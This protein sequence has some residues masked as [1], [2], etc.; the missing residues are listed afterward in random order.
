MNL[1]LIKDLETARKAARAGAE[2]IRDQFGRAHNVQ[3]KS[4]SMTLVTDTDKAAETA[5]I[6][7]LRN[8]SQ[9][10]VLSEESGCSGKES[11]PIWIVDPLDG[12]SN[13]VRS[14][15]LFAVS[16]ALVIQKN[17]LLGV[18]FDPV[19][20]NEYYAVSER[21]ACFNN[22][23]VAL[24]T[25]LSKIPS[26]IL[27]HGAHPS[28]KIKYSD[29]TKLLA[30]DFNLRKLG[31]TALELCFVAT[32]AFD[33][34]ICAGDEIWDYTAGALIAAEAGNIFSDWNGNEW[35]GINNSIIVCKPHLRK[36][37]LK[38]LQ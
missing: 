23:P 30:S 2:I 8:H 3:V 25:Q 36:S 10:G 35:D 15:P 1:N 20:W 31:T 27:N 37:L 38:M 24:S 12:T 5:I 18:V 29:A 4:S 19:N 28:D 14:L 22:I 32:G 11:G 16:V 7:V 26:V 13:F 6:E 21:G 33:A 9:Y 34:F 17:I